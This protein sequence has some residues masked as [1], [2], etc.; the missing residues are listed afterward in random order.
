MTPR[1]RLWLLLSTSWPL[2]QYTL[3]SWSLLIYW[4][5]GLKDIQDRARQEVKREMGEYDLDAIP[6]HQNLRNMPFILCIIKESQ[7]LYP[8]VTQIG[9]CKSTA[10]FALSDGRIIPKD[11]V[12]VINTL[13]INRDPSTW[14]NPSSFDPDRFINDSTTT[15]QPENYLTYS[16]GKRKCTP[17]LLSP[18]IT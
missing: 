6:T 12:V 11:T 13:Q 9:L 1:L 8:S 7:R 3:I 4:L 15:A 2:I 14:K 16:Y 5:S 17:Y 18:D 10:D